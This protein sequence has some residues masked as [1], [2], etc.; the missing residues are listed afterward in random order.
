MSVKT[1][2]YLLGIICSLICFYTSRMPWL[3]LIMSFVAYGA[4]AYAED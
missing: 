1:E 4:A 3:F 2:F